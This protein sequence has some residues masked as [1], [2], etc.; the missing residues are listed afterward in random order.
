MHA[1]SDCY[2]RRPFTYYDTDNK[3]TRSDI[4]FSE[5]DEYAILRL[6]RSKTDAKSSGAL[7]QGSPE[8]AYA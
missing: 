2:R 1:N 4:T 3:L 7:T 6:K 5:Y 8:E